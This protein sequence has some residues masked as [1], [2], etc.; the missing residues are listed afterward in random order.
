MSISTNVIL[1]FFHF[2]KGTTY[3]NESNTQTDRET[4]QLI[5]GYIGE[6]MQICQKTK[7]IRL[8]QLA[9]AVAD[10]VLYR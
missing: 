2:H 9:A 6:I 8:H 1:F 7:A 4:N 10:D 3:A 5:G